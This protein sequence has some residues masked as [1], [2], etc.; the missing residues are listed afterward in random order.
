MLMN[1]DTLTT[2]EGVLQAFELRSDLASIPIK[3]VRISRES[4]TSLSRGV[5][6]LETNNVSDA[7]RLHGSLS[8]DLLEV[9]GRKGSVLVVPPF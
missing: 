4:I 3:N 1:L 5:C 6:Y 7:V 2:E 8:L 9:D